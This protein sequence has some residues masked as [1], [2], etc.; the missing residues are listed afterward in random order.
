MY[1]A[2]LVN[3]TT[4]SMNRLGGEVKVELLNKGSSDSS[5]SSGAD[6]HGLAVSE[7]EAKPV[8]VVGDEKGKWLDATLIGGYENDSG[9]SGRIDDV[10]YE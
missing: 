3:T 4:S 5:S 7:T 1:T 8:S 2:E 6:N 10:H 9:E